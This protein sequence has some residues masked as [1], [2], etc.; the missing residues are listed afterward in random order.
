[1]SVTTTP[2]KKMPE[3]LMASSSSRK[4][5]GPRR[6]DGWNPDTDKDPLILLAVEPEIDRQY[7]RDP[8]CQEEESLH[9]PDARHV[10]SFV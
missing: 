5:Q 2:A 1:M 3:S 10:A 9:F 7:E 4:Q 6:Q 8:C